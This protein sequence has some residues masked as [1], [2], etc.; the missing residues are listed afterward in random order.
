M[1]IEIILVFFYLN[2]RITGKDK[3]LIDQFQILV[4]IRMEKICCLLT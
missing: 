3:G 4:F 1:C 2:E